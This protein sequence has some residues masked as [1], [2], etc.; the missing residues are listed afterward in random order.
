MKTILDLGVQV[1]DRPIKVLQFGEGNFL[2][3]FVDQMIDVLNEKTGFGGNIA[4][5]KPIPAGSLARFDRQER[6][7]TVL[8]RGKQSGKTVKIPRIVTSVGKTVD[9]A[10]GWDELSFLAGCPTLRFLVSKPRH[11]RCNI[12]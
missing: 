8:L 10:E 7:Y 4:I 2:R 1:P 5:V 12:G 11:P 6:L 9:T 3:A